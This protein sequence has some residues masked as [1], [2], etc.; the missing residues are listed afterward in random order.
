MKMKIFNGGYLGSHIEE[1]RSEL[2]KAMRIAESVRHQIFE[3][4]MRLG[5]NAWGKFVSVLLIILKLNVIELR[6]S[7]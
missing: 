3:R 6:F 5:L 2:R 1:E 4:S 7:H